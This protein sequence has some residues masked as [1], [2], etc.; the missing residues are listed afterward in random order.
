MPLTAIQREAKLHE[1]D[2]DEEEEEEVVEDVTKEM[3]EYIRGDVLSHKKRRTED[4]NG[5]GMDDPHSVSSN[6]SIIDLDEDTF[7]DLEQ[8]NEEEDEGDK[9][10]EVEVKQEKE[11]VVDEDEDVDEDE[12]ENINNMFNYYTKT[13]SGVL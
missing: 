10:V 7:N 3:I 4:F 5:M 8:V 13:L 2:V 12:E 9:E 6:E 11:V 1:A